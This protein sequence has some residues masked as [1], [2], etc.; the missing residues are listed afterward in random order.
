MSRPLRI[1]YPG[2]VYH[3]TCRG[4]EKKAIYRGNPVGRH[5]YRK[6]I[7]EDL[8][9]GLDIKRKV[10]GQSIL[11]GDHF[12]KWV[13]ETFYP[14][15]KDRDCP[16]L[17]ELKRYSSLEKIV[18][19]FSKETGKTIDEVK[20]KKHPLRPVLMDLLYRAGGLTGKEIGEIFGVGYS[21]VSQTRKRLALKT[22]KDRNLTSIIKRLEANLSILKN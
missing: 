8:A 2:A 17:T 21:T 3:V 1:E 16:G 4:N 12:V 15:K 13:K 20:N 5:A 6:R 18:E 10:I 14:E 22:T 9:G 7:K 11:D 19:I